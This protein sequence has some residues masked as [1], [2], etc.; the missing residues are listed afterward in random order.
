M[1]TI[2]ALDE[3]IRQEQDAFHD[4]KPLAERLEGLKGLI[5]RGEKRLE[6]ARKQV[7]EARQRFDY[8]NYHLELNK[9]RYKE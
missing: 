9:D 7:L 8:E 3:Q 4:R 1:A 6:E 5:Q 2:Y